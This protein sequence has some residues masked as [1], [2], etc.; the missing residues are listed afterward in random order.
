M[1][2][3]NLKNLKGGALK[4]ALQKVGS[5]LWA[6]DTTKDNIK[7]FEN[8]LANKKK[9]LAGQKNKL[10]SI[11]KD[12]KKLKT[13]DLKQI[14]IKSAEEELKQSEKDEREF[15]ALIALG[16]YTITI[17]LTCLILACF[18]GVETG[19]VFELVFIP[20]IIAGVIAYF[21]LRSGHIILALLSLLIISPW[22][23][24]SRDIVV[25]LIILFIN[26]AVTGVI[27]FIFARIRKKNVKKIS[28]KKKAKLAKKYE[29]KLEEEYK[30]KITEL[31]DEKKR[32]P[33]EIS[34]TEKNISEDE[35]LLN[36]NLKNLKRLEK[37]I[38]VAQKILDD[39]LHPDYHNLD[40][41][42][43]FV[44]LI[45]HGRADTLKE[46]IN[47]YE[48]ERKNSEME[49]KVEVAKASSEKAWDMAAEAKSSQ[50][51]LSLETD[52]RF[53]SMESKITQVGEKVKE[54]GAEVG[55]VDK[56]Q[57]ATREVAKD[58]LWTEQEKKKY[59]KA[60][61]KKKDRM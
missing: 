27:T 36:D 25:Y 50:E 42:G 3:T 43:A 18:G 61:E 35:K 46:C 41:L 13:E 52:K 10:N 51:K 17:T 2:E 6:M 4:K 8:N 39:N 20:Y 47:V 5:S 1:A 45:E 30:K 24:Y 40:A 44:A 49:A 55:R 15:P 38:K 34:T 48:Q 56:E 32:L 54:V 37:E 53:S 14:A 31:E 12:I 58:R 26:I 21:F 11:D 23:A 22:R 29:A 33:E 60:F 59:D 19:Q 16:V 28:P 7:I 9:D 57:K